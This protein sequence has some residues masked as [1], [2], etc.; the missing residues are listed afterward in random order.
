MK[1]FAVYDYVKTLHDKE[2]V[3]KLIDN[4]RKSSDSHLHTF[5]D[6]IND[7]SVYLFFTTCVDIN[8]VP[9]IRKH[10]L[11][12]RYPGKCFLI[13]DKDIS[14]PVLPG[15]YAAL[16]RNPLYKYLYVTGFYLSPTNPYIELYKEQ[17]I[18]PQFLASFQGGLSSRL[19]QILSKVKFTKNIHLNF[20]KPQ[21]QDFY[22][23]TGFITSGSNYLTKYAELLYESFFVLCPKGNGISSYRLFESLEA[24]RIPIIISDRFASPVI[25]KEW[26]DGPIQIK[27]KDIRSI[28]NILTIKFKE[29]EVRSQT[30]QHIYDQYFSAKKRVEYIG[31]AIEH[32]QGQKLLKK[33]WQFILYWKWVSLSWIIILNKQRLKLF[34]GQT[35]KKIN[36]YFRK[37]NI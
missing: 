16:P 18:K 8:E 27:E 36:V 23:G 24:G 5:T 19:R 15:I 30:C 11:V 33:H 31:N 2:I 37:N 26:I 17:N 35:L 3:A 6:D 13:C 25:V 10:P 34:I 12:K 21:W 14:Y 9:L 7:A 32:I 20:V 29:W 4:L 28:E 1:I 22:S